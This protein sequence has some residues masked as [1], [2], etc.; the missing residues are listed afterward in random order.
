MD[1]LPVECVRVVGGFLKRGKSYDT[2][3][4]VV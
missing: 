1:V 3:V 2:V 4:L